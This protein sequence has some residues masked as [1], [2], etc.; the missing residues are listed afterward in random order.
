MTRTG[1]LAMATSALTMAIAA[2]GG[3]LEELKAYG[4]HLA[5]ECTSCHRPDGA[6]SAI[7]SILGKT[8]DEFIALLTAYRDGR[9]TNQVMI[10]VAKS[11]DDEQMAALAAY[12]GS[13][14][15]GGSDAELK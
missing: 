2:M 6:P 15:A 9:K 14:P 4:R 8:Q 10:S 13:L 3:D 5:G 12:F 7:P 1:C 11:L